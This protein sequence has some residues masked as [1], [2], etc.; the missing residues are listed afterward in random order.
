[1]E[2]ASRSS[3][4]PCGCNEIQAKLGLNCP[5]DVAASID[6]KFHQT[7]NDLLHRVPDFSFVGLNLDASY[8]KGT[9]MNCK[10][11]FV[12][13]LVIL[14]IGVPVR[15]QLSV[16]PSHWR[17]EDGLTV[18]SAQQVTTTPTT[19]RL[20]TTL[21]AHD[22]DARRAVRSLAEKK[23]SAKDKLQS[24]DVKPNAVTISPSRILGWHS[25]TTDL[26]QGKRTL[27]SLQAKDLR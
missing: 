13:P 4:L 6:V 20:F 24:L 14:W 25:R 22:K 11:L 10:A 18:A 1:M 17:Q 19:L 16:N 7:V 12:A 26:R 27:S 23:E 2:I 9:A 5:E 8:G 3:R 21:T 15:A